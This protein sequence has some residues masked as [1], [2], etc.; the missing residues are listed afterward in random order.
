M[1]LVDQIIEAKKNYL[2][3]NPHVKN[4]LS[5][6]EIFRAQKKY[7]EADHIK[8]QLFDMGI[9]VQDTRLGQTWSFKYGN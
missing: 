2:I 5:E 8:Q 4:M 6:R 3:V 9:D 7:K 1:S